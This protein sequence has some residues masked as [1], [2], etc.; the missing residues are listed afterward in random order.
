MIASDE[1][2]R[3][4]LARIRRNNRKVIGW[5]SVSC[6]CTGCLDADA[7]VTFFPFATGRLDFKGL[8]S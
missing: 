7:Y 4:S 1:R 6:T 3:E 2:A 5:H 8:Q